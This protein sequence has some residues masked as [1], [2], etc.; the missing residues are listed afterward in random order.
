MDKLPTSLPKAV[1]I[2]Q[3]ERTAFGPQAF[4]HYATVSGDIDKAMTADTLYPV[5]FQLNDVFY[6]PF[7]QVEKHFTDATMSVH[8]YTNAARPWW[9]KNPP[10]KGSYIARICELHEID[11]TAALEE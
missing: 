11:P 8:I 5:P 1:R 2:Y 9:R 10:L 6:D 7:S 4:T 3:T